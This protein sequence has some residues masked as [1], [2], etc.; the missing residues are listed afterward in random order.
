MPL[1]LG[2]SEDEDGEKEEQGEEGEEGKVDGEEGEGGEGKERRSR[3]GEIGVVSDVRE[4]EGEVVVEKDDWI[5]IAATFPR[6]TNGP[7]EFRS[8]NV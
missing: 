1:N 5:L 6:S 7:G 8:A 3:R 2:E 4:G